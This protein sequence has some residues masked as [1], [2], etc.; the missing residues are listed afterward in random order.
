MLVGT[1]TFGTNKTDRMRIIDHH[2]RIVLVGQLTN[3][4][5]ISNRAVHRK[6]TIGSDQTEASRLGLL[7]LGSQVFHR[8]VLVA[9][10]LGFAQTDTI[11]DAR[12]VEFIR[13]DRVLWP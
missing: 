8:V 1:A 10:P 3:R 2:Q 5:Q 7:E 12:M 11:D 9:E 13:D 6:N 4:C